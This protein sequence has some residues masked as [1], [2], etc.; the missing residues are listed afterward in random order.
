MKVASFF[1]KLAVLV[2][3]MII[4]FLVGMVYQ[5]RNP[6]IDVFDLLPSLTHQVKIVQKRAG[7][8]L[9]DAE[10]GPEFKRMVNAAVKRE[11][12]QQAADWSVANMPKKGKTK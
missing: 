10:V 1:G 2:F 6:A 11:R 9:I 4:S 12:C 5:E 7:C 3:F 8:T